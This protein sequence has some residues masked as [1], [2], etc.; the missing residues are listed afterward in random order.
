MWG[1]SYK[2][3]KRAENLNR[4]GQSNPE[5]RSSRKMLL[6][7]GSRDKGREG[8]IRGWN[9]DLQELEPCPAGARTVEKT[10]P[11]L[12]TPPEAERAAE[13]FTPLPSSD[14]QYLTRASHWLNLQ[15][16]GVQGSL[17]NVVHRVRLLQ[18]RAGKDKEWIECHVGK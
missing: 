1:E 9:H 16:V 15:D 6:S 5:I 3:D 14:H 12:E 13:S 10:Q 4:E 17:G 18:H 11:L 7:Q 2:S 8:I